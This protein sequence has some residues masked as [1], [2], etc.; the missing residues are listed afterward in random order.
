MA[1][2]NDESHESTEALELR[3]KQLATKQVR[4]INKELTRLKRISASPE[5]VVAPEADKTGQFI[6][7]PISRILGSTIETAHQEAE[8]SCTESS[9]ELRKAKKKKWFKWS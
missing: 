4:Q 6:V 7:I 8:K 1:S 2:G 5:K 3:N 9:L